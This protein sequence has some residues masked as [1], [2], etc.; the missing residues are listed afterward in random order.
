[1]FRTLFNSIYTNQILTFCIR[2][3]GYLMLHSIFIELTYFLGLSS[4]NFKGTKIRLELQNFILII[5]RKL[6][7]LFEETSK[8]HRFCSTS[9]LLLF[10]CFYKFCN[11]YS[12]K[13]PVITEKQ[14][15]FHMLNIANSH[16]YIST[17][18]ILQSHRETQIL[19]S[20]D[21][22]RKIT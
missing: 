2:G 22:K 14:G 6:I 8:V 20:G 21:L 18:S 19:D 9:L 1:M 11:K 10:Y 5:M 13:S 12:C 7:C 3:I 15:Y 4:T 17:L 16:N